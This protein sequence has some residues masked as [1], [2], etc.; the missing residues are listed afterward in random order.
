MLSYFL[1]SEEEILI[2]STLIA[3]RSIN[4]RQTYNYLNYLTFSGNVF[5]K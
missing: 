2:S 3:V 4:I 5:P 1:K